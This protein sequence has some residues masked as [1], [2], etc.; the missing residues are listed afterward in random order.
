MSS[1]DFLLEIV[2]P[3]LVPLVLVGGGGTDIRF[4]FLVAGFGAMGGVYEHSGYDL[5]VPWRSSIRASKESASALG[6]YFSLAVLKL[7]TAIFDNRAHGEHHAH[8][9]VSFADGFGSPGLCDTLLKTR[10]DLQQESAEME[11][12][13]QKARFQ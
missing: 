13:S 10:W 7:W 1:S 8:A 9:N 5:A 3:Y 12:Q 4:H 6:P 11:W 2:L